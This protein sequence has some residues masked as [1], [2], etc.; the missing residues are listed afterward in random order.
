M[1]E[2]KE[3]PPN[4]RPGPAAGRRPAECSGSPRQPAPRQPSPCNRQGPASVRRPLSFS[5]CSRQRASPLARCL[6]TS[7]SRLPG[8]S[9]KIQSSNLKSSAPASSP[10]TAA[11]SRPGLPGGNPHITQRVSAE[12]ASFPSA[13]DGHHR[14]TGRGR[15]PWTWVAPQNRHRQGPSWGQAAPAGG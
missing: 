13:N 10:Q 12:S 11:H 6:R 9:R 15:L 8:G 5:N 14:A 1:Q 3:E 2:Q 4:N 7:Q